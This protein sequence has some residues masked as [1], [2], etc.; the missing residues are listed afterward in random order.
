MKKLFLLLL[1]LAAFCVI[2]AVRNNRPGMIIARLKNQLEGDISGR[3]LSYRVYFFGVVPVGEAEFSEEKSES[4]EGLY[5][6]SAS[7]RTLPMI[8]KF[9]AGSATADS[10]VELKNLTPVEFR[11]TLS[12]SGKPDTAKIVKYDQKNGVM[13]LSG[14]KRK[15]FPDTQDPLSAVFRIRKMDFGQPQEISISLNTN[16]KNYILQGNAVLRE[17]KLGGTPDKLVFVKAQISRRDKNPYHRSSITM[18]L[19]KDRQNLPV[20][21]KVFAGGFFFTARLCSV[22]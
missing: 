2:L 21:F 3:R 20:L 1:A 19:L 5:H 4:Q 18:V 22:E 9:F 16:Q 8:A 15:I 17:I 10:F 7:A 6:L 12:V 11:Q 14:V 13:E